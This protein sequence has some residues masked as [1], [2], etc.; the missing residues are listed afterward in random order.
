MVKIAVI[1]GA[2]SFVLV[3]EPSLANMPYSR[4][5][6]ISFEV[7]QQY[8]SYAKEMRQELRRLRLRLQ[9]SKYRL[10]VAFI[11]FYTLQEHMMAKPSK[12]SLDPARLDKSCISG[13]YGDGPVDQCED[14][15]QYLFWDEV[16]HL[17]VS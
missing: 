4:S 9:S 1:T 10:K 2:Y 8:A 15:S 12:Y 13:A 14:S 7:A 6:A 16:R 3:A 11:D 17:R 5:G